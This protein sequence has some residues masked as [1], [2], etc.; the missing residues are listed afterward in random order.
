MSSI[1]ADIDPGT[2]GCAVGD[3]Y[4]TFC[5]GFRSL[6]VAVAEHDRT[7]S[8][9]VL[10]VR[11]ESEWLTR[12]FDVDRRTA[13]DW[14]RQ[15]RLIAAQPEVGDRFASGEVSV[16]KLR[17]MAALISLQR[18][19]DIK[20]KGPFDDDD[21]PPPPPDPGPQPD[22]APEPE[23]PLSLEEFLARLEELNARQVAAKLAE[24]RA[25]EARRRERWRTRHLDLFRFD[26]EARLSIRNG[27]LFDDDAAVVMA[28]FEDYVNRCG[29][30]PETGKRDPLGM[31][32]ADA[33]RAMADAYLAQRERALGH[34]L[35]VFHADARLLAGDDNAWAVS[36]ADHSPLSVD[37]IRRLACFSKINMSADDPDGNPLFLGRSQRLASWQQEYTAIYRDGGCRGCGSTVGLEIHHLRE[38]TAEF[39][40]TNIDELVADCRSC[41]HLIH[42]QGWRMEGH[43]NGEIRLLD[44]HGEVRHRSRPHPRFEERPRPPRDW[45]SPPPAPAADP[46]GA[47]DQTEPCHATLW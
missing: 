2:L 42:D 40:L 47:V 32:Y 12:V 31:R 19:E 27:A 35:V 8:Y 15:A 7:E 43:P 20:P 11:S 29:L 23:E 5:A 46:G 39:G 18:P 30:N 41:H 10:G 21:P 6:L 28:A 16:D 13:T 33:L 38:W 34:P 3:A 4:K 9:K 44:P 36:G 26:G 24:A 22:P 1:A 45:M 25:E 37:T 17:S 14:T